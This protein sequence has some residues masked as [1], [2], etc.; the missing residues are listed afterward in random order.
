[1]A[2]PAGGGSMAAV[3]IDGLHFV[4]GDDYEF[5]FPITLVGY[6]KVHDW[7]RLLKDMDLLNHHRINV[8]VGKM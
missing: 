5:A 2:V 6:L 4:V 1:M 3:E 7:H 8:A